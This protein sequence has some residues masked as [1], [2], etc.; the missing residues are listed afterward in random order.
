[1]HL[2]SAD[3][4]GQSCQSLQVHTS[5]VGKTYQSLMGLTYQ[6]GAKKSVLIW[7]TKW[8]Q[9]NRFPPSVQESCV[10]D[11]VMSTH[12]LIIYIRHTSLSMCD[13]SS[14]LC[15]NPNCLVF[16]H[17]M[18]CSSQYCYKHL[19]IIFH[20]SFSISSYSYHGI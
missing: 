5:H 13:S 16:S 19:Q 17:L 15:F 6:L 10:S 2:E 14:F 12:Y 4:S 8:V 3:G 11:R 18:R 20:F 9:Y 7:D 1:M